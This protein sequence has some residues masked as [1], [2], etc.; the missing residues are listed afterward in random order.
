MITL[1]DNGIAV[2]QIVLPSSPQPVER[3]AADELRKYLKQMSGAEVPVSE[4]PAAG[5]PNIFIGSAAN[6]EGLDLSEEAL[7]FDGY[8]VQ[9]VGQDLLLTGVKPYSC[10]YAV[11]HLLERHLGC[12]FFEDGDQVP[13][14]A[15]VTVGELCEVEKPRFSWR[16]HMNCMQD[17]YT[18]IRWWDEAQL[19]AWV[20]YFAKKRLNVW[21]VER[22]AEHCGIVARAATKLGV[23]IPLTA[24]QETRTEVLRNVFAHARMLGIRMVYLTGLYGEN[25]MG[26]PGVYPYLEGP[27]L[28]EF[29]EQ[30]NASHDE[31]IPTFHYIWCEWKSYVMDP[32]SPITQRFVAACVEAY[33]V[34][35]G[36]DHLYMLWL[37]SEGNWASNDQEEM[38]RV[39]YAMAKEMVGAITTG[40]A[41]AEIISPAPFPYATTFEAQ[42]RAVRDT[43]LMVGGDLWLNQPGRMHDFLMCD[44]YWDLAWG[45]G[46]SAQ[47]GKATN[48][49]VDLDLC[50][51][52]AQELAADPR[53]ARCRGFSVRT[54]MSH[55]CLFAMDLFGELAW[56][57]TKVNREDTLRQW[58]LRRYGTAGEGL[59]ESTRLLAATLYSSCN[60]DI[61]NGPLYRHLLGS[62]LPGLTPSSMKRTISYLPA[63]REALLQMLAAYDQLHDSP[64]YRFDMVDYER[65]YL[66][67]MFN[68]RLARARKAFR[69]ANREAFERWAA[70]VETVMHDIARLVSA[71]PVFRLQTYDEWANRW[72]EI[73]PGA[74]NAD[75][76]WVMFTALISRD[77]LHLIDYM[78]EDLPEV[79]IGYYLP[80]V[81]HYLQAMRALLAEGRDISGDTGQVFAVSDWAPPVGQCPW[82]PYGN[83]TEPELIAGNRELAAEIIRAETKSGQYDFFTGPLDE[84]LRAMLDKYPV[85]DDLEAILAEVDP[86][87][88]ISEKAIDS[89][90]GEMSMGFRVPNE[91]SRVQ[92]P[93]ELV[94]LV[95]IETVSTG[96]NIM[97]DDI[98]SYRAH[99]SDYLTLTRRPDE[100]SSI[101]GH[102]VAVFTFETDGRPY[103]LRYDAGSPATPASLL[104]ERVVSLGAP[105]SVAGL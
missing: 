89:L 43:G 76:N 59:Q 42:K 100:P 4:T 45:T 10:L 86:T 99:V 29:I 28:R 12:G 46:M 1:I 44:Y 73:V 80:R 27:Q 81:Q 19:T 94:Y 67:A 72:P 13:A 64:L 53:A 37:P 97:R 48:P 78:G 66:A 95:D 31:P 90:P 6:R 68:D 7:G 20:D 79:V 36:T 77:N 57:P 41:K 22:L 35:L 55:K 15:T 58:T 39:T 38:N 93:D 84:L 11:Y 9:T 83:T 74:P 104:I 18:G 62:Y 102:A 71:D 87:M 5:R 70:E 17:A 8:V 21:S 60:N 23:D 61:L 82:S 47:C 105:A 25:G 91:V 14:R 32:R 24:W 33:A 34:A 88:L 50:I 63:L 56:N 26:V 101:D 54:E 92:L 3:H 75:S 2:A 98:A 103:K 52:N 69:A 85:P 65:T 49:Y 16:A 30:Y 40:D 51:R 96:Y